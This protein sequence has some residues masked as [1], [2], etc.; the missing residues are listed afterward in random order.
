MSGYNPT[1]EELE[2]TMKE[3]KDLF[4]R[5]DYPMTPELFQKLLAEYRANADKKGDSWRSQCSLDFLIGKLAEEYNE[6]T[7]EWMQV[8]K[9]NWTKIAEECLDLILVAAMI[10]ERIMA[11]KQ[12]KAN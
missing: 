11:F 5:Y 12:T 1:E 3:V 9:P 6:I 8:E 2:R 4:R 10:H 7:D